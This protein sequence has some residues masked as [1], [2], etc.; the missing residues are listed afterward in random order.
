M[1]AAGISL[2]VA[3]VSVR[4]LSLLQCRED[5]RLAAAVADEFDRGEQEGEEAGG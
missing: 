3:L 4:P 2:E 5:I 1:E